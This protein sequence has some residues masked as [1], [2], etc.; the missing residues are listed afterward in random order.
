MAAAEH[1]RHDNRHH[2]A[3]TVWND[4][5]PVEGVLATAV[6]WL[7]VSNG[8]DPYCQPVRQRPV[9]AC[10]RCR[11]RNM[12]QPAICH[13]CSSND[14]A[15][16]GDRELLEQLV[17]ARPSTTHVASLLK[18]FGDLPRTLLADLAELVS[19]T[20]DATVLKSI[21]H[22]AKRL[23]GLE[24]TI[25]GTLSHSDDVVR[26]LLPEMVQRRVETFRVLFLDTHNMLIADETMWTGSVR[27]VQVHPR[28]VLRRALE[29]DSSALILAHNHPSFSHAP[30]PADIDITLRIISCAASLD[31]VVHD[32]LIF[33]RRG[34]HSMRMHKSIDPWG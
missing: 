20:A 23:L 34:Y 31:I 29:L 12:G 2:S 7:A 17:S 4:C 11:A 13:D 27:D 25:P 14:Q 18:Q 3:A 10:L 6:D 28:E 1:R 5:A 21:S 22:Q 30:S 24:G 16:E 32:H 33:S 8:V 15:T 26:L 9:T 19:S